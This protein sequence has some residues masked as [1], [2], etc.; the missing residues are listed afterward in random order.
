MVWLSHALSLSAPA[1]SIL[2]VKAVLTKIGKGATDIFDLLEVL[3]RLRKFFVVLLASI[4][5]TKPGPG[6]FEKY[7][8]NEEGIKV[9][10]AYIQDP[11]N[12]LEA[13]V[14]AATTIV[15][16]KW[17]LRLRSALDGTPDKEAVAEKV[18]EKLTN[19]LPSLMPRSEELA[20]VR[21][22]AFIALS[23][24]TDEQKGPFQKRIAEWA[25]GTLSEK[26]SADEVKDTI[27]SKILT[28]QIAELGQYGVDAACLLI[29]H[30]FA[31][32]KMARYIL[33]LK[34]PKASEKML[35]AFIALHKTPDLEIPLWHMELIGSIESPMALEYL[36]DFSLDESRSEDLRAAAYN[37]YVPWL[38]DPKKIQGKKQGIIARLEKMIAKKNPDD[39]WAAAKFL[40]L[41]EGENAFK[42]VMDALVDDNVYP[43]AV[44][45][46]KKTLVDFC[47]AV[48]WK[49]EKATAWK[50][51]ETLLSSSNRVH[52]ALGIVCVKA[53]EDITKVSLLK[54]FLRSKKSLQGVFE[55]DITIGQLALNAVEGLS[56]FQEVERAQKE[57]KLTEERAKK[58]KFRILV[59]LIHTGAD[60]NKAVSEE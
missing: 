48:I 42:K 29:R 52:Q 14:E 15:K 35:D 46:P 6:N 55:E 40:I 56:M 24:L 16:A 26:S 12:P 17:P 58:K 44:E 47:T 27:E 22:G 13:R 23:Y 33:N 54:P 31:V 9:L 3:M 25:F 45:D 8:K 53:S 1:Y 21:D 57:G 11:K 41:L 59:E 39:R 38:L 5:C 32:E 28:A 30:G 50:M 34:E 2:V 7:A 18:L 37:A 60:Y 51:I 10:E 19:L 4:S 43:A 49:Q 20:A 36:L